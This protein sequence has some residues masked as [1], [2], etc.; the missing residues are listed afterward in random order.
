MTGICQ[1]GHKRTTPHSCC[2]HFV[3]RP[4]VVSIDAHA[5]LVMKNTTVSFVFRI[6]M[7]SIPSVS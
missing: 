6:P 7:F 4:A 2:F 1:S 5:A 3:F